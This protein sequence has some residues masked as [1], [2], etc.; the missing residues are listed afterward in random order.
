MHHTYVCESDSHDACTIM[1][2]Q[3]HAWWASHIPTYALYPYGVPTHTHRYIHVCMS[4]VYTQRA[5]THPPR[6]PA[7][8]YHCVYTYVYMP[9]T[10][11]THPCVWARAHGRLRRGTYAGPLWWTAFAVAPCSVTPLPASPPS[12]STRVCLRASAPTGLHR[13]L[14]RAI[15]RAWILHRLR[16]SHPSSSPRP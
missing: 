9:G 16:A 1:R 11:T 13:P 6:A 7:R 12:L 2:M 3:A 4:T 10:C 8:T 5:G 15:L 14:I